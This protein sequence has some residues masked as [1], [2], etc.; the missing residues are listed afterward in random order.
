MCKNRT[1]IACSAKEFFEKKLKNYYDK[2]S[3]RKINEIKLKK[4]DKQN[5]IID[6]NIIE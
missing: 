2:S 1:K 5:Y 4:K 6:R 3:Q